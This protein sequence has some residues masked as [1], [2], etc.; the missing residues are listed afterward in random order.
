MA[1]ALQAVLMTAVFFLASCGGGDPDVSRSAATATASSPISAQ[2]AAAEPLRT[3]APLTPAALFDWAAQPEHYGQFFSGAV[4]EGT[5]GPYTYRHYADTNSYVAVSTDGDVYA[6]V[7]QISSQI[8]RVGP[9]ALFRCQ[10]TPDACPAL[11]LGGS[12]AG[13]VAAAGEQNWHAIQLVAGQP[14]VFELEGK[15]TGQGTMSDPLLR[16]FDSAG[17]ELTSD[18]D[19][20]TSFNSRIAC[21]PSASGLYFLAAGGFANQTGSYRLSASATG[22]A[23]APC[24]NVNGDGSIDWGSS[25]SAAQIVAPSATFNPRQAQGWAFAIEGGPLPLEVIFAARGDASLYLTNGDNLAACTSGA[26]FDSIAS[27]DGLA[28]YWPFTLQP[29]S[30]GL[31]VRNNTDE[32]NPVRLDLHKQLTVAGF[33]FSQPRFTP[34]TETV[35][36][37]ERFTVPAAVGDLYRTLIEAAST[38]GSFFVIPAA[39]AQNFLIGLPFNQFTALT[40][41]C[42]PPD[43]S[44]SQ[45]CELTGVDQYVIAYYND[46][47]TAQSVVLVGRDYVPD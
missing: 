43:A 5:S 42:A 21:F 31:C 29:G 30:Y 28:G 40:T 46:T 4:D 44:A 17:R 47:A 8:M 11:A 1:R 39:E 15:A 7:P 32:A 13:T 37:G 24:G 14:Y 27:F 45:L 33:H 23:G 2:R 6:L 10:I 38:G 12:V 22:S 25:F 36:P 26:A 9:F 16:L 3:S 20:G 35:A 41:G 19:S 18:D 34:M